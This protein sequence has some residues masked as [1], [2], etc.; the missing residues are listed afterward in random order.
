MIEK[1]T[2]ERPNSSQVLFLSEA[3]VFFHQEVFADD[4]ILRG[5]MRRTGRGRG[6]SN[7]MEQQVI[8]RYLAYEKDTL[9]QTKP[10]QGLSTEKRQNF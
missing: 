1:L 3:V 8:S 2:R 10:L 5:G 6:Q 4:L 7:A 9:E